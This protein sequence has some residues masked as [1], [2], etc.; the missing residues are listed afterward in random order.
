MA[1]KN[2]KTLV[3][4][5]SLVSS[6]TGISLAQFTIEPPGILQTEA[7]ALATSS[8]RNLSES[9]VAHSLTAFKLFLKYN[10][11]RK[12][13]IGH[14]SKNWIPPGPDTPFSALFPF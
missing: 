6:A 3:P 4:Y 8:A 5:H 10:Y 7:C 9:Y 14:V 11:L 12:A 1:S 13:F 2:P